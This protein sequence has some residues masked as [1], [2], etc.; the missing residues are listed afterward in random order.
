MAKTNKVGRPRGIF[1]HISPFSGKYVPAVRYYQE[2][3]EFKRRKDEK[4]YAVEKNTGLFERVKSLTLI[5]R[6]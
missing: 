1:K 4:K 3:R 5:I 6:Y 2:V